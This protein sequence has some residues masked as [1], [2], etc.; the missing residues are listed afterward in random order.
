V[1]SA[2]AQLEAQALRRSARAAHQP[3]VH[4]ALVVMGA[5]RRAVPQRVGTTGRA[6]ADVVV[7]QIAV[8]RAAGHRAAPAVA[9]E[10]RVF[11][12][13]P[14]RPA[15][16]GIF[17]R[18]GGEGVVEHPGEPALPVGNEQLRAAPPRSL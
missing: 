16:V 15:R 8:R 7:V 17:R 13:Q 4:A 14:F 6:E 2:Q 11:A 12:F 3:R 1:T 5:E 10:D 9:R 18:P